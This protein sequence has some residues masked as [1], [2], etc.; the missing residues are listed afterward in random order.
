VQFT[1]EVTAA[2]RWHVNV[3]NDAG[4]GFAPVVV[5]DAVYAAAQD[6]SVVK[7]DLASGSVAWRASAARRLQAGVGSDGDT[8]AVVTPSGEVIAFD[9]SGREIW[10]AMA[11][12]EVLIPPA[13]GEGLVVVRSGDYRV[14]AVD[15]RTGERRW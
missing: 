11:S 15:A 6:G 1:P 7:I 13:V 3:G 5:G 10:R 4:I 2:V 8:T 9:D 14:Q 12:S